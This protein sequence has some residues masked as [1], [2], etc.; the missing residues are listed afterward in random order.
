MDNKALIYNFKKY[1]GKMNKSLVGWVIVWITALGMMAMS[2]GDNS[3]NTLIDRS[4][5]FNMTLALLLIV[6]AVDLYINKYIKFYY[7]S[8]MEKADTEDEVTF[9]NPNFS[10]AD[11]ART[12][13]FDIGTYLWM[14]YKKLIPLQL[15]SVAAVIVMGISKIALFS[16]ATEAAFIAGIILIPVILTVIYRL[17]MG[18]KMYH[19]TRLI[20][21]VVLGAIKGIFGAVK[22][23]AVCVAFIMIGL[24]FLAIISSSVVM[25]G[26]DDSIPVSISSNT[27]WLLAIYIIGIVGLSLIITDVSKEAIL[28][29]WV[30]NVKKIVIVLLAV[31]FI[32]AGVFSYI[33]INENVML[34][35]DKIT[36]KHKGAATEYGL[37]D[38]NTYRIYDESGSIQMELTFNDGSKSRIFGASAD[39]TTAWRS[40]YYSNYNYGAELVEKLAGMG[41]KGTLENEKK[42]QENVD[43]LDPECRE[44]FDRI[45]AAAGL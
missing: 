45:K 13:S 21:N 27:G 39:D 41:V 3:S 23:V 24:V 10:V 17:I 20:F 38:I 32:T 11:L 22:I 19:G 15:V 7:G 31:V 28:A 35:E 37:E 44:G 8:D 33:A 18:Y 5:G 9:S 29:L 40:R 25:K 30:K 14:V 16:T 36:V 43:G 26:I 2:G 42:L 34:T 4:V 1:I 6:I 12:H